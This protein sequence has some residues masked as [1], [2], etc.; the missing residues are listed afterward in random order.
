MI[1]KNIRISKEWEVL[2]RNPCVLEHP[3]VKLA[4]AIYA[5]DYY[6]EILKEADT[7]RYARNGS[8]RRGKA[9]VRCIDLLYRRNYLNRKPKIRRRWKWKSPMYKDIHFF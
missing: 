4:D 9:V 1:N 6:K 2:G 3:I 5:Q 7:I 8:Y